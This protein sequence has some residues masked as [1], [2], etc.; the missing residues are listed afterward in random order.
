[1]GGIDSPLCEM[2][3][4]EQ[5]RL[6]STSVEGTLLMLCDRCARFGTEVRRPAVRK[7]ARPSPRRPAA[8]PEESE[9][10]LALDFPDRIR[11]ARES[12]G[13]KRE[14]LARKINEKLSIIE[15][16]E[17]GKMRPDDALISKLE[18]ALGIRLRERIG[19]ARVTKRTK[20]RPLTLGD[21]IRREE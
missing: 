21:L 14:E 8:L 15:K 9:Y 16:L 1:M 5:P 7:V 3:G 17:K 11:K 4:A 2:C 20:I 13:W 10:D 19:E 12:R 18:K 6:R